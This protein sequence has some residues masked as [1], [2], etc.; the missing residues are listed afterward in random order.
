[1]PSDPTKAIGKFKK[2]TLKRNPLEYREI[3]SLWDAATAAHEQRPERSDAMRVALLTG[4]RIN[5]VRTM[6]WEDVH[7]DTGVLHIPEP[8]GGTDRAFDL[9]ISRRLLTLLKER[10]KA[11]EKSLREKFLPPE[12]A[13]WVFGAWS[14]S[15]HIQEVRE[16]VPGIEWT[17]HRLRHTFR[18][19]GEEKAG[20]SEAKVG[21][22]MN[23]S[24]ARK[25]MTQQYGRKFL[26]DL[27]PE[28]QRIEDAFFA[29]IE[30][31]A[32][33]QVLPLPKRKEP[34]RERAR[35]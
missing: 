21:T 10:Q 5:D 35:A 24:D 19:V 14:E 26:E 22:L 20:V 17:P 15:G 16:Q 13:P 12:A 18:Q 31:R 30:P 23:H 27:R 6:R 8:K 33:A 11:H 34:R 7:F 2:Q 25:T 32:S 4:L 28:A 9:P 1:M 29:L 3:K